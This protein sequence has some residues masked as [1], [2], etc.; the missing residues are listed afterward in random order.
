M[1]KKGKKSKAGKVPR[2]KSIVDLQR[3]AKALADQLQE[4]LKDVDLFV[5]PP[6]RDDCDICM[7]TLPVRQ[8]D[9]KF[10]AC[11]GKFV[12][13]GC[14]WK[15]N[16]LAKQRK[17]KSKCPFCRSSDD[18]M[19]MAPEEFQRK[20]E[21]WVEKGSS[22]AARLLASE[23][24][25]GEILEKNE[26]KGAHLVLRAA[27]LG[28]AE[29]LNDI[30]NWYQPGTLL[31]QD[32]QMTKVFLEAGAKKGSTSARYSLG[33]HAMADGSVWNA[34]RHWTVGALAGCQTNLDSVKSLFMKG[35][36]TKDEYFQALRGHGEAF[37]KERTDARDEWIAER[38][39]RE[40]IGLR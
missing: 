39:R 2:S 29:A 16:Q 28:S 35:Y 34:K 26:L 8:D 7:V 27:E 33:A 3:K 32:D 23:W 18:P 4:E 6:P 19:K 40:A 9:W 24:V 14:G 31:K 1:G 21:E 25:S 10:Q 5:P 37:A 30:S 13:M 20:M 15:H 11:C 22:Q 17:E 12:C 36:A 38:K